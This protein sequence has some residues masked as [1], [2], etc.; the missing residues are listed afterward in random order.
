[1]VQ[2]LTKSQRNLGRGGAAIRTPPPA[3]EPCRAQPAGALRVQQGSVAYG[4][5]DGYWDRSHAWH[6]WPNQRAESDWR[7]HNAAHFYNQRHYRDHE[8]GWRNDH[9]WGHR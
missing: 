4:Y 1:M 2:E 5:N 3:R 6:P 8:M 7:A 9:W